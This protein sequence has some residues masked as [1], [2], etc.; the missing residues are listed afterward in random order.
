MKL[1]L[2]E[3]AC[4]PIIASTGQLKQTVRN[5]IVEVICTYSNILHRALSFIDLQQE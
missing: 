1:K 5:T 2:L 4:L 3:I